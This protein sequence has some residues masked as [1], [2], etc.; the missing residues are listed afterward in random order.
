M[1]YLYLCY[2]TFGWSL[3]FAGVATQFTMINMLEFSP[4]Q[5]SMAY[6][7]FSTPWCVKPLYG[8]IS[9]K[10]P[11]FDWGQR[12]P[13][14]SMT[15]YLA[16][17]IYVFIDV[18]IQ[19]KIAFVSSMVILSALVCYAD[20]CADSITVHIAKKE[21]V[22][23]RIQSNCWIARAFGTLVG[24]LFGGLAY[25]TLG[26]VNV[27]RLCGIMPFITSIL[28]WKLPKFET[29]TKI[30]V[31]N[32]LI[33]NLLEEKYLAILFLIMNIGPDYGPF[34]TY[35][36][37]QEMQYKPTD[38]AWMSVSASLS[39][40]LSTIT[41]NQCLLQKKAG[42]IVLVG[43]VGSTL[44]KLTQ[45]LVVSG[46]MPY[47][48]IVLGDGVAES[49][50]GQLILMPLIVKTANVCKDGVEGSLYA[51]MMSIANLSNVIGDWLGSIVGYVLGVTQY[52]F[53]N[54]IPFM[55]IGITLQCFIPLYFILRGKTFF[56]EDSETESDDLDHTLEPE[57]P[58][59]LVSN[60]ETSVSLEENKRA[61]SVNKRGFWG[62]KPAYFRRLRQTSDSMDRT[63]DHDEDHTLEK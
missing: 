59:I 9:D 37:Q 8:M 62:W 1:F 15:F 58:V 6:V 48:W 17:F 33:D 11:V 39:F 54:M 21:S 23:G 57:D 42:T 22:K 45:L 61:M 63:S 4:V 44:F 32:T 13:Y 34:Y 49:F 24:A 2:F 43:I 29:H 60:R 31:M 56:Y 16:S 30:N 41:F 38:F 46:M 47:F 20:V 51:L 36:L 27:F 40:L 25:N 52:N 14:I 5:L 3:A 53:D 12:R 7:L 10:F 35:Y 19:S 26:G 55:V 18:F 28:I 50:F